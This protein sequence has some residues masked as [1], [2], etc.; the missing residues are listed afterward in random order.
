MVFN[1]VCSCDVVNTAGSGR[2]TPAQCLLPSKCVEDLKRCGIMPY[3][4]W[5]YWEVLEKGQLDLDPL[6]CVS[7]QLYI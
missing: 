5:H 4:V 7:C 2:I 1:C 3:K 6:V